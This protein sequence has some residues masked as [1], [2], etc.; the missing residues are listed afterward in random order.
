VRARS[1][2][3]CRFFAWWGD[4]VLLR[5]PVRDAASSGL[6]ARSR[7]RAWADARPGGAPRPANRRRVPAREP[8][9]WPGRPPAARARG[10]VFGGAGL[11]YAEAYA[12][13]SLPIARTLLSLRT[14]LPPLAR[15]SHGLLRERKGGRGGQRRPCG[16]VRPTWGP[17]ARRRQA[18]RDRSRAGRGQRNT[19]AQGGETVTGELAELVEELRGLIEP[20]DRP[21]SPLLDARGV[22]VRLGLAVKSVH[23]MSGPNAEDAIPFHRLRANGEKRFHV[24]EVDEWLR[25][26]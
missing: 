7:A 19:A 18:L 5:G 14:H 12:H 11:S 8:R 9:S 3:F 15:G 17:G 13:P 2:R 26:H 6:V 24:D 1:G 4:C 25:D 16:D 21:P 10:A 23:N 22:A 20:G